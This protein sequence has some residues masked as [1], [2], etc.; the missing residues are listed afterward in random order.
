MLDRYEAL[1]CSGKCLYPHFKREEELTALRSIRDLTNLGPVCF[2]RR[3]FSPGHITGSALVTNR[4]IDRV[5][6]TLHAKLGRWLQLG[7]H[8]D[9]DPDTAAVAMREAEEESGLESLHF[10]NWPAWLGGTGA[11]GL[12]SIASAEAL[13]PLDL[14]V[15][16]IPTRKDDP[17]H[18]H[19]DVRLLLMADDAAPLQITDESH[20]LRWLSLAEARTLTDER[21][22]LRQFD[23]LDYLRRLRDGPT[24]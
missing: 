13:V 22:M 18:G 4:T 12:P 14:D 5:L 9:G 6:L 19:Y 24:P 8:S 2:D 1:W 23:K 20:D 16:I 11:S 7:G 21:S 3:H 17:A 10:V 15:H